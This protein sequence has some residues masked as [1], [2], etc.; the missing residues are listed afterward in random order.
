[1]HRRGKR[2]GSIQLYRCQN[3]HQFRTDD[4]PPW[5]D[6]FIEYVVYVYLLCLSLN[7]TIDIVREMFEMDILSKGQILDFIGFVA[8]A[9]PTI[10]DLDR[11]Y[12]PLRSGYLALDGVWFQ[13]GD[14][15][16]VLLVAFDPET[17]DVV[18]A[19]WE[20]EETQDGY[21]LLITDC[22]NK[23]G[24]TNIKGIYGDGDNGLIEAKKH[25]L[26][27]APF[28]VCVFHKELRMGH[29]VPVK[30]V[31]HSKKLTPYQKHDIKVFQ[32]LFRE[33]IYAESKEASYEAFDRL[34]AYAQ[35]DT[36]RYPERFMKAY[37]SLAHN[38]KY[39]LT[40]FDH[41]GMRRDNNLLECFNG[42]IKP[43]LRLM[44]G[45][46]KK[47]NLNRYLKLFLLAFRFHPL[48]ESR[49]DDRRGNSPLEVAGV[50]LPKYYNFLKFLRTS[51]HLTYQPNQ[52]EV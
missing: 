25:L 8:D 10:D 16:I 1:M 48:K 43:R 5:D 14:E 15:E 2:V 7:T 13:Y 46:K 31:K 38:F 47:E 34:K 9:L 29:V 19:R 52:P 35:S 49:F 42:C 21:E 3:G 18:G 17:F 44:K 22:V 24:I 32:L 20:K 11:L 23:I 39:T 50:L 6:S 4:I 37:R 51:L 26:P 45:F 27:Y 33:V 12:N 36:H 30:S 41:T 40:H 28:Q